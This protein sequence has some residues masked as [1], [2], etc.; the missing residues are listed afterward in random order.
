[1]K[2]ALITGS[3]RGIGL[4]ILKALNKDGYFTVM[5]STGYNDRVKTAL[6]GLENCAYLPCDISDSDSRKMLFERIE[7]DY[8][9][10]DVLVNNAG[11][12]PKVR[13]DL[14]EVGE[15]SYDFVVDTNQKGTFFVTQAA[16]NLMVKGIKTKSAGYCPRI[17]NISSVSAYTS[18]VNRAEYCISKAGVSMI[19]KL[20]AD[21]LAEYGIPVFE[22]RP[23]VIDTDMTEKVHEKYDRLI[24]DGLLPTARW[25][26]PEDVGNAVSL[27]CSGKL[28]YSTGQVIDVDGGFHLRRL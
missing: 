17:V 24:E 11:V 3:S 13:A 18:S 4:G 26:T 5:S 23:G 9:R 10:L 14:L 27:L 15:E 28:D 16:A 21:R 25:G 22:V 12:A 6:E 20:F 8:G 7:N 2:I 19:T 1:M